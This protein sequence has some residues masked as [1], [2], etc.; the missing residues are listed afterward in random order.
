MGFCLLMACSPPLERSFDELHAIKRQKKSVRI[1][2]R[3]LCEGRY[4]KRSKWDAPELHQFITWMTLMVCF[5]KRP[6]EN[7]KF[8]L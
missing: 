8:S 7:A 3:R 4:R 6:K 2:N 1:T 5:V